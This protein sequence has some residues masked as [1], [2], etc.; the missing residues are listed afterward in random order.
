[1][2]SATASITA[3]ASRVSGMRAGSTTSCCA[4]HSAA[5]FSAS[6]TV[7]AAS[8]RRAGVLTGLPSSSQRERARRGLADMR[9]LVESLAQG[10][11]RAAARRLARVERLVFEDFGENVAHQNNY[12]IVRRKK[13]GSGP[14][15]RAR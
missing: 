7:G 3:L 13:G 4:F 11:A 12:V 15:R 1:M 6:A 9:R 2:A 10:R 8:G 14:P 5:I